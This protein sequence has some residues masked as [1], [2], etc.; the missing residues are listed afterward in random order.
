[1]A[2]IDDIKNDPPE[3]HVS[4]STNSASSRTET[5][6]P[7]Q[8]HREK[9]VTPIPRQV[10]FEIIFLFFCQHVVTKKECYTFRNLLAGVADPKRSNAPLT[11]CLQTATDQSFP[12]RYYITL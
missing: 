6:T 11:V 12:K 10:R 8:I 2:F 1:M 3:N 5:K 9:K 7:K 4:N